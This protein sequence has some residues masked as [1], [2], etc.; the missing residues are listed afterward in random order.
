MHLTH[1]FPWMFHCLAFGINF[2][3]LSRTLFANNP[4][5]ENYPENTVISLTKIVL[6]I[7]LLVPRVCLF[8]FN[9][10]YESIQDIVY[11]LG[12]QEYLLVV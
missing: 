4:I 7:R 11:I 8:A 2:T 1:F 6:L 9:H 5:D 10:R 12:P 3:S